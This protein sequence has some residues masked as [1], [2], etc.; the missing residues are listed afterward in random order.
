MT[1]ETPIELPGDVKQRFPS[2]HCWNARLNSTLLQLGSVELTAFA[3][4]IALIKSELQSINNRLAALEAD[5]ALSIQ[6]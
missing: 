4:D 3:T 6:Q 5:K 2:L 1:L